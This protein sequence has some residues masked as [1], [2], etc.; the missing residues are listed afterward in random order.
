MT[1]QKAYTGLGLEASAQP[2]PFA[3]I[4][5]SSWLMATAF[6]AILLL[7]VGVCVLGYLHEDAYILY[8]YSR[9]LI[10]H[11]DI[12]FDAVH[13]PT[14]GATDFLWMCLISGLYKL[15]IDPGIAAALLN[16]TGAALLAKA[17][18]Q[19]MA[20]RPTFRNKALII[21]L[22]VLSPLTG[23]AVGGFSTMFYVGL[24]AT[25]LSNLIQRR[26]VPALWWT[27]AL[28]LTRPDAV[29]LSI[30][31]IGIL[32]LE[33]RHKRSVMVHLGAITA[34]GLA[35]FAWR[36][37]YFGELL[38][39][40][41]MVKAK[42][43][44][45][46][47]GLGD[48]IA[49]LWPMLPAVLL[50]WRYTPP[51]H[52]RTLM[53]M[54]LPALLLFTA[55]SFAHQSQNVSARFQAPIYVSLLMALLMCR[56]PRKLYLI[57]LVPF[58]LIGARNLAFEVRY[59]TKPS[60]VNTFPAE[61]N[62]ELGRMSDLHVAVTEAGRFPYYFPAQYLD[63]VGLNSR[64]VAKGG[65]TLEKMAQFSPELVFLHHADTYDVSS[66][67]V[68]NYIRMSKSEF[69]HKVYRPTSSINPVNIAPSMAGQYLAQHDNIDAVY[70]VWYGKG[71]NHV[72]FLDSSKI[73]TA[74]F[75]SALN[76][77]FADS[78]ASHCKASTNAP[79]TWLP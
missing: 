1:T 75:E 9:N 52:R 5:T 38:P 55:L 54:W 21:A 69:L 12:A 25:V 23:A 27:L 19:A 34:L 49:A 15:R 41:L 63:I 35:Y 68:S 78:G 48:N 42:G 28:C 74:K 36:A 7:L 67:P 18:Y 57:G 50:A 3:S 16:A 58:M 26:Y 64:E 53:K 79:C 6:G 20:L 77:S 29:V 30:G 13:G 65:L 22:I 40:P 4:T 76:R 32:L 56:M 14:E 33:A 66:L 11:G 24:Y 72:Y 45:R 47:E 39:L 2:S 62:K 43:D 46:L 37:H 59:L 51:G 71:Y 31:T 17:F 8:I 60:Y 70:I 44:G 10:E 73:P 61:L